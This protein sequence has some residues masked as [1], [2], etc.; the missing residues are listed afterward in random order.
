VEIAF[1][2]GHKIEM[3][4][5]FKG[6]QTF[7]DHLALE[8]TTV[9][10]N[11]GKFH[12]AF[13][14]DQSSAHAN[15]ASDATTYESTLTNSQ[16]LKDK[17][18]AKVS[19][20]KVVLENT[21][22][23]PASSYGGFTSYENFDNLLLTGTKSIAQSIGSQVSPIGQAFKKVRADYPQI[24]LYDDD[25]KHQSPYGA[26]LKACVNYLVMYGE[27]FGDSP[28]DCGLNPTHTAL[29]RKAAEAVVLGHESDYYITR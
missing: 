20:C 25:N 14:Q 26:Y 7:E 1:A 11:M 17:I 5:H 3:F 19:T 21:W 16:A 8:L 6:S 22:S 28:A 12:Y 18:I 27:P 23:F 2:E 13:I 9:A 24:Q 15:Y 10:I 4:G 29:L